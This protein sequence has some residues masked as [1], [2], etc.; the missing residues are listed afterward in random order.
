MRLTRG[1]QVQALV[2]IHAPCAAPF[3]RLEVEDGA[4]VRTCYAPR[5]R[6]RVRL[7]LHRCSHDLTVDDVDELRRVLDTVHTSD[8]L[9]T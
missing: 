9:T 4:S 5:D 6:I 7:R 3:T 8:G 1:I 2:D